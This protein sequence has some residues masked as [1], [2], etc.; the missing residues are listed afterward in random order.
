MRWVL[1]KGVYSVTG[2]AGGVIYDSRDGFLYHL[3]R[4]AKD[5]LSS[6][7]SESNSSL[8]AAG[9]DDLISELTS[10]NLIVSQSTGA[11]KADIQELGGDPKIT[12]AWIEVTTD[13]NLKCIHCYE[14]DRLDHGIAMSM[15]TYCRIIDELVDMGVRRIQLIGGEP[16]TTPHLKDLLDY[17]AGKFDFIEVYTN[18]TLITQEW[19]D[20]FKRNDI[21]VAV[22]IY[23]YQPRCHDAI[24]GTCGSCA[25]SNEAIKLMADAGV[26]Y[27]VRNVLMKGVDLGDRNTN[28]YTLS[29]NR[30]V[31]RM[32]GRASVSLLTVENVKKRLITKNSFSRPIRKQQVAKMVAGNNCFSSHLY[33]GV[34]GTVYPCVMERRISHGNIHDGHLANLLK[35][36]ILGLNK[37]FV[38]ECQDCEYRYFCFDCRPDSMGGKITEKP[39][40]CTYHPSTGEWESVDD[41]M[42]RFQQL[43]RLS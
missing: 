22:S 10:K 41:F 30:D 32:T 15:A 5:I 21:H 8:H 2:K 6:I 33:F 11:E 24:T 1:Q 42:R 27:R 9:E 43:H 37:D 20:Y 17:A 29:R 13:C 36:E 18:A 34:D 35:P 23:S 12:F 4:E 26:K 40:Y 19:V 38:D 7:L 31:V 25:K 3:D 39:W 14:G 28:L 16:M